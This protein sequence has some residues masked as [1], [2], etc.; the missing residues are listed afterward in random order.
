VK[1]TNYT[2]GTQIIA[3]YSQ[4]YGLIEYFYDLEGI[5]GMR[6]EGRDYLF[7]RCVLGNIVEVLR[8][9]SNSSF[10]LVARYRYDAWGNTTVLFCLGSRMRGLSAHAQNIGQNHMDMLLLGHVPMLQNLR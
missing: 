7:V 1:L 5:R 8:V 4:R 3:E 2:E 10:S 9:Y 6:R